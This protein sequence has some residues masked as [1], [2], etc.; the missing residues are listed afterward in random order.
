MSEN[1]LHSLAIKA[2]QNYAEAGDLQ[3]AWLCEERAFVETI[4]EAYRNLDGKVNSNQRTLANKL[5]GE[6]QVHPLRASWLSA[7]KGN[8]EMTVNHVIRDF[9]SDESTKMESV[10]QV[11]IKDGQVAEV[12]YGAGT[13]STSAELSRYG[14]RYTRIVT[15]DKLK[16]VEDEKFKIAILADIRNYLG[17]QI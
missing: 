2:V 9:S 17:E 8:E 12:Y 16:P 14:L 3:R 6:D 10:R 7:R 5:T 13:L 11:V 1:H 15:D 4:T